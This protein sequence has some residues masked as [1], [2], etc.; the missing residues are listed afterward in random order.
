VAEPIDFGL[1]GPL[2]VRAGD[3]RLP[4]GGER[5][6]RILAGLLLSVGE[7]VPTSDLVTIVWDEDPPETA[8]RQ[9]HNGV[10]QLR[11]T[12][13]RH[14]GAHLVRT[15]PAGYRL[16]TE[17]DRVDLTRFRR[18]VS[19]G[20]RLATLGD[21][22]GA[23]RTL[24]GAVSLWRGPALAG[25]T[26]SVMEREAVILE[27]KRLAAL[28]DC[29]DCE[30]ASGGVSDAVAELAAL[31]TEHP[32]RERIAAML[33]VGLYRSGRQAEALD[34]Y[35]R[36]A[37]A[38][39]EELGVDPGPELQRQYGAIL[40][41]GPAVEDITTTA[42]P[43]HPI[44][45][46]VPRFTLPAD[47]IAFTG[48]TNELKAL[49]AIT[50]DAARGGGVVAIQAIDGMPGVGKTTLAVHAAHRFAG[51]FPDR[52][53]FVDLHAHS[54]DRPPAVPADA[55]ADLLI[56]DGVDPR[57]LPD[58]LDGRA[59]M[60]RARLAGTRTLIVLDN[61]ASTAQISPLLPG[62]PGCL[63]LVTSRRRLADLTATHLFLD[64][65]PAGDAINM[66]LRLAPRASGQADAVAQVVEVCG[67]LPLAIAITASLYTRHP[68]WTMPQLIAE[69]RGR[70]LTA[71][72][73]HHTVKAAF[74]LSYDHLP[75]PRQRFFRLLGLQPG[76]DID[77]YAAAALTKIP[78]AQALEELEELYND[79]L[80]DEPAYRRYRMHDLIRDYTHTQ[81][82]THDP[83]DV[84]EQAVERLLRFY[85]HTAARADTYL[86]RHTRPAAASVPVPTPAPDINRWDQAVAWLRTERPN[87]LAC[88][89]HTTTHQLH[90]HTVGLTAGIATLLRTDGPWSLAA[91][92][93][94]AAA[95]TAQQGGDQQNHANALHD[96]SIAR[97][98]AGDYPG[99]ADLLGQALNLYRVI[100]DRRGHANILHE[101]GVVRY[102]TGDYPGAADLLGQALNL[103]QTIGDPRGQ[104]T[105]LR[106]LGRVR[107]LTGDSSGA[108]DLL[109]KALNMYQ[110]IGNRRG[111]AIAL[112]ELG[113]VRRLTEDCLG[114][115]DLL[116]QALNL[117][118]TIG[119][120][121]DEGNVLTQLATVRYLTGDYPGAESLLRQ[122]LTILREIGTP[123]DEAETLNH[124]GALYR[125]TEHP[126]QAHAVYHQA[127]AIARTIHHR[128]EEAHALHGIGL[129]TLDLGDTTTALTHLRQAREIYQRLGVPEATQL[130]TDLATFDAANRR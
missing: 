1:L 14:G 91:D 129:A 43:D 130:T 102:L 92:L 76:I 95:A 87:L 15:E 115:A 71:T 7:M 13:S 77:G 78:Y 47:T 126:D 5:Q 106:E 3:R 36:A 75:E 53:V 41:R 52:Q 4:L 69:I 50:A 8:R 82:I 26:G 57:Q 66:F 25:V 20:R 56:A 74:D 103:H 39:A 117:H 55:L 121:H 22:L 114:A 97:Q 80:L 27:E 54:L 83:S 116:G 12:L 34:V 104:A 72:G 85:H 2:E 31:T 128:L 67:Y 68:S 100:D 113:I 42:N 18:S 70:R 109:G 59:G 98:L 63:V 9:V 17:P 45:I 16:R 127:L 61:A 28:E 122:A 84:R 49:A 119:N 120:R 24:R 88:V 21:M 23:A 110:T 58:S 19:A 6:R 108:I 64:I 29:L 124:L 40:R 125:L 86:S 112:S 48:R 81:T 33:M 30:L 32:L 107:R 38:L 62:A 105:A 60:W 118:Q 93:H 10:W 99:A 11:R 44:V 73:E 35:R 51:Q 101:L 123:H 79:H 46:Q 96:L 89:R 37:T 90:H 65:L 94:H 111:Q